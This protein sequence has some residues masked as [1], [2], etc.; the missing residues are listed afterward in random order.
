[1]GVRGLFLFPTICLILLC[2][3]ETTAVTRA[4]NSKMP[5][6]VS[7]RERETAI[8]LSQGGSDFRRL[9]AEQA[10]YLIDVEVLRDKD[11]E[12]DS[13]AGRQFLVSHYAA[14]QNLAILSIVDLESDRL[15][16]VETVRNLP[17]RLSSEEFEIAK[18]L[19]LKEP[20]VAAALNGIEVEI[21]AQLSRTVDKEDPQFGHRVVHLLFKTPDGY[22]DSPTVVVDVTTR[23]VIV[24]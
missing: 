23:E 17:V 11:A 13:D 9:A 1:M 18:R 5:F 16:N 24:E 20:K 10:I 7:E 12:N 8:S 3:C 2:G 19:A 22:L 15:V 6:E 14:A 21:E 4:A